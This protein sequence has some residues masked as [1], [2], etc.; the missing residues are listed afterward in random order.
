MRLCSK[1]LC[2]VFPFALAASLAAVASAQRAEPGFALN[3]FE[4]SSRG[5]DWFGLESLDLRGNGR[6]SAGVVVDLAHKPLVLY[7][8]S[9]DELA[10]VI[11]DQ[12]FMHPGLALNVM[13]RLR[14]SASLPL[15]I[16]QSGESAS[17]GSTLLQ[18]GQKSSPGDLRAGVDVGVFGE[19]AESLRLAAGMHVYAPTGER[20]A[21]TSDAAW[22][23]MPVLH[24]AGDRGMLH[25]AARLG[26]MLRPDR[27]GLGGTPTGSEALAGASVGVGLLGNSLLVGP[28]LYGRTIVSEPSAVLGRGTT[29]LELLLGAHYRLP[30][31]FH[32]GIGFGP[33][34]SRGM[35]TPQFRGVAA[36]EWRQ[37]VR[38][39]PQREAPRLAFRPVVVPGDA[40]GDGIY[41]PEDACPTEHG[42]PD[43]DPDRHG[44]P[45]QKS[46]DRDQ[47]GINDRKD[48]CPDEAG[49]PSGD[50]ARHGCPLPPPK[51]D[52]TPEAP[53]V[54]DRDG[55]S[56]LDTED[57]C[58]DE[59][60]PASEQ[61][62]RHGCPLARIERG[63]IAILERV[64]FD[65]NHATI[66]AESESVLAAVQRVLDEHQEIKVLSVE[67]HTDDRGSERHNQKLSEDRA[68]AVVTWLVGRGIA[69]ERLR[70]RGFGESRP[71]GPNTT[72][73]GRQENRRVEFHIV[74]SESMS[75]KVSPGDYDIGID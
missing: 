59:P 37:D 24:A 29:P 15:L 18:A 6:V 31:G 33:G 67:G 19:H 42:V 47:D 30:S 11:L 20:S 7:D 63:R 73:K 3:R 54:A 26:F 36:L 14:L 69:R 41:D 27:A 49:V 39:L 60:G 64:E 62:E 13:E 61:R 56:I 32:V 66:R 44:C 65:T 52:R 43:M 8:E 35:G 23:L 38:V 10:S 70:S 21:Y 5:S 72:L 40:D 16:V 22:R 28:E 75:G 51:E 57:A 53:A 74:E 58:P 1:I 2:S 17:A 55:D 45:P 34:L 50:P 9:G 25:Y 48:A 46:F 71:L 68:A 12:V 4:P